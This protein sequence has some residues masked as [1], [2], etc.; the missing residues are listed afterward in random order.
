MAFRRALSAS[1][2]R[3]SFIAQASRARLFARLLPT[4]LP[5]MTLLKPAAARSAYNA[6]VLSLSE[7][8]SFG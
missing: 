3:S 8:G 4:P 6:F 7:R 1:T 5:P 2:S